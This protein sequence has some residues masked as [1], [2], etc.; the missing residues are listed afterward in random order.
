MTRDNGFG[1]LRDH[2]VQIDHKGRIIV[3]LPAIPDDD[4]LPAPTDEEAS[5]AE[6]MR[7]D[8]NVRRGGS[9]GRRRQRQTR[10]GSSS[11]TS[12]LGSDLET[13]S[14][15]GRPAIGT[16]V[17]VYVQTSIAQRT[18]EIL[19]ERGVTLAEVFDN[20]AREVP[21]DGP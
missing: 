12:V 7:R 4:T 18:R 15:V 3:R 1:W 5:I 14:R 21:T 6:L 13:S 2:G 17:R 9:R 16:E 19:T 8:G 10:K 11:S 20:C